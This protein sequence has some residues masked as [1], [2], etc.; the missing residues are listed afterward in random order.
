MEDAIA[1][2]DTW[3]NESKLADLFISTSS[4]IYGQGV[5]GDGYEDVFKMNLM[6]IDAAVHSDSSNLFGL[7]DG[8]GYYGYLGAIGLTVRSLTGETPELYIANQE[9]IDG[10]KVMTLK[11]AFRAELR[12]RDFN[13]AW[14]TGMMEGNY[15]G[16]R[17]MSKMVE[18]LWGW[19]ATNPDLVTDSDWDEIYDTYVNDKYDLGVDEFLKTD[20]PYQYQSMTARM[21]ETTRKGYWDASDE[22]IQNLVKEYAES[23]VKDGVTCCHHTCG[24]SL[25]DEYVQGI[26]SVPGVVDEDTAEKYK[27]LMQEATESSEQSSESSSSSSS[28]H[29]HD[30]GKA[31][32]VSEDSAS[33]NQTASAGESTNNQTVQGSDAGYGT[34]SPEPSPETGNL[35][36]PIMLKAMRC[37]KI[38]S[39]KTKTKVEVC[40][41]RV[42]IFSEF[43]LW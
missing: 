26:M 3:E 25:L 42:L 21:L 15:A 16:A 41:F 43:S 7:L 19:D 13:P 9:N 31:T 14:I 12:A 22:V 40:P 30:T 5:W 38:L 4:Y 39:K 28:H 10:L 8:D 1:A 34:D 20:N 23:V 27:E 33:S 29:D 11:D 2:S 32:V 37:R 24:N 17:Q 35:Q 18:Y 36:I 6:D